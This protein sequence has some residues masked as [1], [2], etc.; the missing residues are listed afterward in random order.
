MVDG[1]FRCP[2]VPSPGKSTQNAYAES[3]HRT[4]CH[5][6]HDQHL[7]DSVAHAQQTTTD[8]LWRYNHE[9]PNTALGGITSDQKLAQAAWSLLAVVI[10]NGWG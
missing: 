6:W 5:A 4:V 2:S 3:W 10:E 8:W 9:R 7:I 1:R